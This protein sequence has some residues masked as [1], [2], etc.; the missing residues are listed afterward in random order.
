[1]SQRENRIMVMKTIAVFLLIVFS[2][3]VQ[4]EEEWTLGK[5]EN[6][7]KVFTKKIEGSKFKAFRAETVVNATLSTLM[8][9][10]ADVEYVNEWLKDCAESQLLTEFDPNGYAV[11]FKTDSP[12]P[13]KD[14]D[15]TLK[16]KIEQDPKDYT[17]TIYFTAEVGLMPESDDCVRITV[18]DGFWK[19]KPVA[20]GGVKVIYQVSTDPGGGVP[21]WLANSF[22]IDQPFHSLT[23][24][25]D[26]VKMEKYQGKK[27]E[28]VK[29]PK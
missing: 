16:Y 18:L 22:V 11:Y 4:A 12:W 6:G 14:R 7:I 23:K 2:C 9:V 13:V 26:R 8:A 10:H 28:F 25:H 29:E 20:S 24:L 3:V 17:L 15:Y 5:E 27:F 19:M 1:M 21:A